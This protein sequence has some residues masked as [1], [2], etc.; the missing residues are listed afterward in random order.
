[1]VT[2]HGLV[3]SQRAREEKGSGSIAGRLALGCK[4]V[5]E[6]RKEGEPLIPGELT[7]PS[8]LCHSPSRYWGHCSELN[9]QPLLMW[10][11]NRRART[12]THVNTERNSVIADCDV[13]GM[14][15]R[16]CEWVGKGRPGG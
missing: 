4:S 10:S 15:I 9:R 8:S 5:W 3:M 2:G 14:K 6:L 11:L 1:M 13:A 12:Q 7:A 16:D